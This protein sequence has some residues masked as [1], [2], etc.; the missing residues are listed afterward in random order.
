MPSQ[1]LQTCQVEVANVGGIV[2]KALGRGT[3]IEGNHDV[4]PYRINHN[5]S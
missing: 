1:K 4:N 5:G 2:E 3:I